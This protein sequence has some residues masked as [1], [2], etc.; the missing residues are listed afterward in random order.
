MRTTEGRGRPRK[1]LDRPQRPLS[2][3][4]SIAFRCLLLPSVALCRPHAAGA[5]DA[6]AYTELSI[7]G[8]D[9]L[10]PA[11]AYDGA[12]EE[13]ILNIYETLFAFD[14]SSVVKL[15]P[16]LA[17]KV[18]SRRNGLISKDG[19]TYVI[20]LRRGVTFQDG[21]PMT[22]EDV[23]Y[24]IMR[25]MLLDRAG[26]AS[27]VLL[28]P[29]LGYDSTR[30][31]DGKLKPSAWR[32]A[33]RA[34]Q[35]GRDRIILH[36]PKPFAP[37]RSILASWAPVTPRRWAAKNGDWD[38]SEKTLAKFNNVEKRGTWLFDHANGTGPFRLERWDRQA[39]EVVLERN[40]RY[41]RKAARLSRVVVRGV[42]E[43]ETR[44]L[45]L[46]AGDADSIYA[47]WQ[48]FNQ[49]KALA[50][51]RVIEDVPMIEINPMVLFTYH[52]Q[53]AGNPFI[54]SGRLDGDGVPPDLFVDTDV[55]K[56]FA[57]AFDYAGF[58]RD[59]SRG[60]GTP[61]NGC[62]PKG[63][64][65]YEPRAP[66]YPFDL[67]R[68]RRHLRR[69]LGGAL[70][71]RGFRFTMLYLAGND[72]RG[73]VCRMLAR[74]LASINPRFRIDVRPAEWPAFLDA[75]VSGRLPAYPDAWQADYPD[76]HNFAYPLMHSKG[77][78]P[79]SQGFRDAEADKIIEQAMSESEPARRKKLYARLIAIEHA[80]VPHLL[81]EYPS[82][83]RTQRT[84]VRG[85]VS[86]PVFP[87][88]PY[89][90][91]YYPMWKAAS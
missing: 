19:R 54:G 80:D 46:E 3:L 37:L 42:N 65:G 23:R 6:G 53:A 51:V 89:G 72:E 69:A 52:V 8:I 4:F 28:Q 84:W 17:A 90:A 56:G 76:P 30:D 24:S 85:W 79:K 13:I 39:M 25:F 66:L 75:S 62:I 77:Y 35:A 81:I 86:N 41:W 50:G 71:D 32:D 10:D 9:S 33:A 21:S 20:P 22:P 68:A 49:V 31:E 45:M 91:Y 55:R 87:E 14:K 67:G 18:P 70:W 34:V 36:L 16:R 63:L 44:K 82:N 43:F 38:G 26:G 2:R 29:L 88:S 57:Y 5:S 48:A 11:W 73:I 15:A 74:N 7:S 59:V 61:A 78:Y 1:T 27:A 83:Y 40:D 58:I 12:S 47:T 64:L 60:H